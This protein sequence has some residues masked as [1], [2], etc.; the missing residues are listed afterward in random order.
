MPEVRCYFI[1]ATGEEQELEADL[2]DD[3][4]KKVAEI[5]ETA[6]ERD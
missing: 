6:L 1:D 3:E 2:T 4:L 5:F